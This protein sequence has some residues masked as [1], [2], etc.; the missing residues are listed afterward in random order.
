MKNICD[1]KGGGAT[2]LY[3]I[4]S[5][6]HGGLPP[7]VNPTPCAITTIRAQIRDMSSV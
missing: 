4:Y 1:H 5:C 3:E 2:Y 6:S 7:N